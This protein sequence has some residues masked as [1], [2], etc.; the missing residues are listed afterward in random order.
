MNSKKKIL[1]EVSVSKTSA[2][3][4][5]VGSA[6]GSMGG[7]VVGLLCWFRGYID[8]NAQI[9]IQKSFLVLNIEFKE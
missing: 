6:V 7:S 3:G 4:A 9:R 1:V 5:T 8:L 2:V